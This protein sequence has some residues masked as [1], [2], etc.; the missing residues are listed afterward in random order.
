MY[1]ALYINA[2]TKT[3]KFRYFSSQTTKL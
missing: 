1:K 3:R 2:L